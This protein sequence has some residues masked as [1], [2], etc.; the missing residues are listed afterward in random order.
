MMSPSPD[1]TLS[2]TSTVKHYPQHP[3]A[4]IKDAILGARFELSLAFVGEARARALNQAHRNKTY[5]PDVL[6][7]PLAPDCGEIIIC[8]RAA[9]RTAREFSLQP[10][11]CVGWLFIHGAL[12]LKGYE[13]GATME[14]LERRFLDR[15]S[16]T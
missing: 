15:F 16:I 6:S 13:H 12:H 8:P 9:A 1:A 2:I 3:Y 7:F 10:T 14:R 11:Q 5:V 4:A